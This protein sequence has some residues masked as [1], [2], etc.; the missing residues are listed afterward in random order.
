MVRHRI[1]CARPTAAGATV[2]RNG[3][4][5]RD[6][7]PEGRSRQDHDRGQRRGVH[8]RGRL[9]DAARRHRPAGQRDRRPRAL[10]A[11]R[12][13]DLR[14]SARRGV[15]PPT[16]SVPTSVA[17]LD[18]LP[19]HPDLAGATVELPRVAGSEQRLR[20]ALVGRARP[21]RVHDPRLPAVAGPADD[22]RAGR[23]RSRD[24]P[25]PD[26]VL[27]ARGARRPARH[28]VARPA[29]AQPAPDRRR[30]AADDARRPHAPRPRRR[31]RGPRALP[32]SSC[33]TPS[34]RGTSGSARRRASAAP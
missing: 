8:R 3:H 7:Q 24:R 34:S 6:R 21:L 9:P 23:R 32:A 22:Q 19:S 27:R 10:Q 29:R 4:R 26:R 17:G 14:R 18:L 2:A 16:R 1:N 31:A 20:E 25:G 13:V 30:H 28:P 11:R 15:A 5:L 33:S 12:A